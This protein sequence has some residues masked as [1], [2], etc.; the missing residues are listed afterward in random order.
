[1]NKILL[2]T[3]I[4]ISQVSYA[5]KSHDSHSNDGSHDMS[6]DKKIDGP[7]YKLNTKRYTDF[8]EDLS[9][10]QIAIVDVKGMVCD[11]CARGITKTF[12][13]D[14]TVIKVDVDL[15]TGKIFIAYLK[16]KKINFEDIKEKIT[17]NGQTAITM[18]ITKL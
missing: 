18:K 3:L 17:K 14:D 15:E 2:L 10:V 9:D 6:K 7:E 4:L 5:E 1:M 11:F 8:I 12:Y 16:S 13:K